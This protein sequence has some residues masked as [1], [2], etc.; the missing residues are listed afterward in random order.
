MF[1]SGYV[2]ATMDLY[3]ERNEN[4][5]AVRGDDEQYDEDGE[6]RQTPPSPPRQTSLRQMHQPKK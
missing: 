5:D 1:E 2:C 4:D 6:D 3:R